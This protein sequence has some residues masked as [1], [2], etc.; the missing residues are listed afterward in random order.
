MKDLKLACDNCFNEEAKYRCCEDNLCS[1][2]ASY[3]R[4]WCMVAKDE[5]ED[6]L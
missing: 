6:I 5:M 1:A 4:D 3:H 2:C